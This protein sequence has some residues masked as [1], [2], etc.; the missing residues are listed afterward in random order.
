MRIMKTN[1]CRTFATVAFCAVVV[2]GAFVGCAPREASE[3]ARSDEQELD[4]VT[5]TWAASADCATCHASET[6]SMADGACLASTHEKEGNTCAT[7]HTDET[8]LIKAHEG[9]TPDGAKKAKAL[10]ESVIDEAVCLSCHDSYEALAEKT[11]SSAALTDSDGT[12][13]NPHALPQSGDHA[14]ATCASCHV[15]HRDDP[16]EDSASGYCSS[17]HHAGVFTCYTCHE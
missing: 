4:S 5:F 17:C 14:E 10:K 12:V 15:M 7:C 3:G 9:A 2:A 16:I 8:G 1:Q 13:A 11:A 6:S